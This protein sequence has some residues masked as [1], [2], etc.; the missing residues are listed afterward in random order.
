M[1]IGKIMLKKLQSGLSPLEIKLENES[2]R[3][4]GH[5]GSP[6]NGNSHFRLK[7]VST[8]F[9]GLARPAR[10]RLIYTLLKEE[11]SGPVH[12][13]AMETLTPEEAGKK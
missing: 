1:D 8:A 3:H 5:A 2:A 9:K 6:N 10:H 13:L 4:A 11:L 7:I 12:A